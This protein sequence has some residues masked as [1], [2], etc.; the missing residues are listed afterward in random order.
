MSHA[1]LNFTS[2]SRL[3]AWVGQRHHKIM[4]LPLPIGLRKAR[5]AG[6]GS[7]TGGSLVWGANASLIK[8]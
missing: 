2:F 4:A 6:L 7:A 1:A 5:A 3:P 8:D